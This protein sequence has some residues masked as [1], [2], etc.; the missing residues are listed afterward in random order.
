MLN[1]PDQEILL[2]ACMAMPLF[3][4]PRVVL[5]PNTILR[6][7]IFEPRYVQ[8]LEDCMAGNQLMAI[9][10][11][12]ST[13]GFE[14]IPSIHPISGV[15]MVVYSEALEDNRYNIALLGLRRIHIRE[16]LKSDRLYRI[17][18]AEL[19]DETWESE[20]F[21]IVSMKQL[22]TQ[23]VIQ[24]PHLS[25]SLEALLK[26]DIS[27]YKMLNILAHLMFRDTAKRQQFIEKNSLCD[28]ASLLEEC[29][30]D[31]LMRGNTI[32]E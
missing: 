2:H 25:G 13:L 22:L 11:L 3:P 1:L 28:R 27:A 23:L 16:E 14:S 24:N 32:S 7:H 12:K 19:L 10:M 8:L 5:F 18:K 15:G 9:P 17:A 4:L 29:L 30:A 26:E 6:L 20:E 21:D 31:L